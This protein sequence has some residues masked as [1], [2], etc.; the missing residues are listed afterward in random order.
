MNPPLVY[1]I[2]LNYN[3]AQWVERCLE[4]L[5]SGQYVNHRVLFI[6]NASTD[7]SA[8]VARD[9]FP[10]ITVIQ[11]HQNLGFSAGNNIG[12]EK[13]L[14]D[15]ADYVVLLNPDTAVEAGWLDELVAAGERSPEAGILGAVQLGYDSQEFN[16]WTTQALRAHLEE[17]AAPKTARHGIP[18]EWV[19]GSCFAVKRCVFEQVGLL[20]P[21]YAAFYEEIDFC[22]R[23]AC[24]GFQT[25][26]V[27]RSRIHHYRGGVWQSNSSLNRRRNY[28][29]DLSQFI[30]HLT[31]PR[32][33]IF[34][35]AQ[36]Y[37]ITLG[38]KAKEVLRHK[39]VGRAW[40]LFK[41]QFEILSN[42][43]AILGKW[44][45]DRSAI[46]QSRTI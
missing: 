18:V 36:W 30:Y 4:S 14:A 22:R 27:P 46:W 10:Q 31:E 19:E 32:K 45:K 28:L 43:T 41:M 37:L 9:R 44:R 24:Y 16:S 29:C 7:G 15:G 8:E 40:D 5:M 25:M 21:I 26:I 38:T 12:I 34:Q 20:D 35:N 6:D 39:Q 23:A 1:V 11:N 13:A 2:V 33:S 3:G 42:L 17:L